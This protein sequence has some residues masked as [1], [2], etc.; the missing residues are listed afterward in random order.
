MTTIVTRL[1]AKSE[2]AEAAAAAL[3]ARGFAKQAVGV[4][5]G[6]KAD[7]AFAA[8]RAQGVYATGAKAYAERVAGGA[9]L[10]V[11]RAPLGKSFIARDVMEDFG[12]IAADV[13]HTEVYMPAPEPI[14]KWSRTK[15]L[16]VL[17]NGP[18]LVLSDGIFP[19]AVIRNHRPFNS[20]LTSYSP[21]AG[22]SSGTFSEKMGLP[23]LAGRR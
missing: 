22:L 2:Q 5:S 19:P 8:I 9:A 17:F 14:S 18:T 23:L 4:V 6:G 21:K 13:A 15:A 7:A 11:C 12:P 20:V 16:P 1:Y 10:V 3:H